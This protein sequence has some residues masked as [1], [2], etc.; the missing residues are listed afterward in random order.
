MPIQNFYEE[1]DIFRLK[2]SL[3]TE[4]DNKSKETPLLCQP[5]TYDFWTWLSTKVGSN[6]LSGLC[7]PEVGK[8]EA[9]GWL[10]L[11]H[12][13][14]FVQPTTVRS[15]DNDTDDDEADNNNTNDDDTRR[16]GGSDAAGALLTSVAAVA[17]WAA[18]TAALLAL[19]DV[20]G[21]YME[22]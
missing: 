6:S 9:P 8:I 17:T 12:G 3:K 10:Q 7:M 22:Q 21:G 20:C 5:T 18:A 4:I 2:C 1:Q 15:F 11:D 13:L 14:A 16:Y 19:R